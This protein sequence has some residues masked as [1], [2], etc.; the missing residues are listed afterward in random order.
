MVHWFQAPSASGKEAK[1]RMALDRRAGYSPDLQYRSFGR[2]P[3]GKNRKPLSPESPAVQDPRAC[4][5]QMGTRE[6]G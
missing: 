3:L 4:M 2:D 5:A 6:E 1:R